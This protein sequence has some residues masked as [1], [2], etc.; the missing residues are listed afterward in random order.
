MGGCGAAADLGYQG[1]VCLIDL[2]I[3]IYPVGSW[4]AESFCG[5]SSCSSASTGSSGG[6]SGSTSSSCCCIVTELMV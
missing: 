3:E 5:S 1:S 2:L 6:S 4:V